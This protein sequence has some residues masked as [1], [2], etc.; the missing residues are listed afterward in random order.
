M[1]RKTLCNCNSVFFFSLFLA[2]VLD[3]LAKVSLSSI[4]RPFFDTPANYCVYA[5]KFCMSGHD[6]PNDLEV[7][8]NY[9]SKRG[10]LESC[11]LTTKKH[12]LW[13]LN[14]AG[15][16]LTMRRLKSHDKRKRLYIH[17]Q[18]SYSHQ[19][20]QNGNSPRRATALKVTWRFDHVVLRDN[21]AWEPLLSL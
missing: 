16:W 15:W 6:M 19:I 2:L 4:R 10:P 13:P 11:P 3:E 18:S 8:S 5:L 20:R 9:G 21:I 12:I 7:N 17:Y 14:W 1:Q